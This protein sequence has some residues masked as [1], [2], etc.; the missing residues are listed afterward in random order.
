MLERFVNK[1]LEK[2]VN[3]AFPMPDLSVGELVV[4]NSLEKLDVNKSKRP[5]SVH[6]CLLR[7]C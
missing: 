1:V 7:E 2:F 3:K 5:D 6:P 4:F